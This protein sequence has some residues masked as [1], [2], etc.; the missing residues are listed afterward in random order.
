MEKV[1]VIYLG[2]GDQYQNYDISDLNLINKS[3]I[4][5]NFGQAG[6]YIEYFIYSLDG[7]LLDSNYLDNDYQIGNNVVDPVTGTTTK[8]YVDP[9]R[10]VRK[11]GYDRGQVNIVYNFLRPYLLS[12]PFQNQQFWI[13]EISTSRTEIK[14]ARQDLSNEQLLQ[15]FTTFNAVLAANPY[16][17]DFYLNFGDNQLIIGVNAVYV[18]E[19]ADSYVIFKLYEPLPQTFQTKS[20]FWVVTEIAEP[21]EY[22]VS[23]NVTP[24]PIVD[25]FQIKGPNYKVTTN[26]TVNQT[27]PFYN[28]TNLF[29]TSV[30]SSFQQ[31]KSLM[32]EKG[33]DI[34]VDYSNFSNFIH[35]SS[36]TERL[37]NFVYKLQL[38]E[39]AS[40]GLTQTNT[41]TAKV[42]L[43]AQID[44]TIKNFD[45]YEYFLYFESQSFA[46][47]KSTDVQPFQLYSVTSS[48]AQNWLGGIEVV[49]TATTASLYFSASLYD[50]TN[51]NLLE[52][53]TP[54][55]I[56]DD[57]NNEPY[58]V[59]LN[60]IGQHFDNIWIYLKDVSK[61]YSA[62]NNPFVG[63]SMDQVGNAL[64]SFGVRLYT[65]TSI[66]DNLYYSLLGINAD[67]SLLPPTGS[68][69]ITNYV[70]SS[71]A[72]LP[73]EQITGE[74]YKRLYHNLAYLFKTRGT[75]RGARAL[76]TTFGIP[77]SILTT[78]EYGGYNIYQYPGIQEINNTK[79]VTG[80][81]L[82]ISSSLLSP[83]ATLQ[84]YDNNLDKSSTTV[85][86]GFS[87]ADSINASIT[88]SGYVT[89]SN[90]P[91]Y[92]NIMQ[93]I[94][95][96]N[97]QYSSSYF[98][99]DQLSNTYF[100]AEYT[101]RYDVWDFIRII[102]YY[103]NSL[104]KMLRDW[105]PARVSGDTGIVIKSHMLERN[106][107]PRHE[108]TATTSS[109]DADYDLVRVTGSD[110]GAIQGNTN[111]V[112]LIPIQYGVSSSFL[113]ASFGGVYVSSSDDIQKYTGEFSGSTIFTDV[114][115]FSQTDYSS[116]TSDWTSSVAAPRVEMFLSY[117]LSPT[118]QNVTGS[119]ISQRF[120]DLD[121]NSSQL[122][123]V[124]YGL[125]TSSL[126][127]ALIIGFISQST[128]PYSQFAQFQDY[129]HVFRPSSIPRYSGSYLSG[130]YYNTH[131]F[132][133]VSY[134]NDPVINYY[135]DK[136]GF[137]NQ[138][139]TSSFLPGKVNVSLAYLSDVSGGLFELNQNNRNWEDVQRI[140][141]A[142]TVATVKQFDNKK[143]GN[144]VSTDGIKSLYNSGY[145]YTPQLYF[146]SG[147]D[148]RLYFQYAGVEPTQEVFQ[149]YN[150]GTPNAYIS[151]ATSPTYPVNVTDTVQ[152]SGDIFTIFDAE[153]PVSYGFF[154][155]GSAGIFPSFT[156]S[157][158]GQRTFTVNFG[159]NFE[160]QDP[161]LYSVASGSYSFGA[162]LNDSTLIGSLQTI[163]F[164]SSYTPG[165]FSTGSFTT[166]NPSP[167]VTGTP[168]YIT[169]IGRFNGPFNWTV[170]GGATTT[171]GSQT[172][173]LT[174]SLYTYIQ[175]G[176][177]KTG[178]MIQSQTSDL[179]PY[180][181]IFNGS[182]TPSLIIG[183]IVGGGSPTTGVKDY[184]AT[185]TFNY[186]TPAINLNTDDKVVFRFRQTGMSTAN[187]TSSVTFGT[188]N[189]SLTSTLVTI[190]QG[191]Y[192]Y[193]T[194]SLVEGNFIYDIVDVSELESNIILSEDL[195]NFVNYQFVPY[196]VSA[197]VA[198]S[199]SLY[200]GYGDINYSFDPQKGDKILLSDFSGLTQE[201]DVFSSSLDGNDR[202]NITVVPKVIDNW[203]VNSN[204]VLRC[205][206]LK[207]Y[208][209][210][211]NVILT[212]NKTPGLTSYGFLIPDTIS[213]QV[214]N[215]INTLQAAVQSQILTNQSVPPIDAISGGTFS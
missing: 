113:S 2:T 34:N 77:D 5:P 164:T 151:G 64:K 116:Y 163:N 148:N 112:E 117:S 31:I 125:I 108:P 56:R 72:T 21:A 145:N 13:K 38:I 208:N 115:Y 152:R 144:Q 181:T 52:Y 44:S 28:Y 97:L 98:P 172:S 53:T 24:R 154:G 199:S 78:H 14:V 210:E 122:A 60:M 65:N 19:G 153:T 133:D 147:T 168:S 211:Q 33:I 121:F 186:T 103:N 137:F 107:Y 36:A 156:A 200:F 105:Y 119:V 140:F 183:S 102:K 89:A 50:N 57:S 124:N 134:G 191:G 32:D 74:V 109:F 171:I 84:Y 90:Q 205:L 188:S 12:S 1:D 71:I 194:S 35:F 170:Q 83:Y 185:K 18:E 3:L 162:Y 141:K 30:S 136:L 67:G 58:L 80:S 46:W 189:S 87:P 173:Q 27:T 175:G 59:F 23:I 73:G 20:T 69:I 17:P 201:L 37:Y 96:P 146:I 177:S 25:R 120:L 66:S 106:K 126:N 179:N 41:S 203:I 206:I 190:G 135:S 159:V 45:G 128:Q 157:Y 166:A 111:Y 198:Y 88:S 195:S 213:P 149:G 138:I 139:E 54:Q 85:Q 132:G 9:E 62:E 40:A 8:I 91:G 16:Y 204:L 22:N 15:A 43:Q 104:F 81:V 180:L 207:R 47:P 123:P 49:P 70:T 76:I 118:F 174:A 127:Q 202:L 160:F 79:I 187:F 75:E 86:S 176:V 11:N 193:A 10:D 92:F 55:Y 94:G 99:L 51:S 182:S 26:S 169:Q 150:S 4:T 131:S 130:L 161:Q 214:T 167:T 101:A 215:N 192:P 68:E 212:F 197:S 48:Q 110:G 95:S 93:Y 129:L 7:Q 82:Q 39:T 29:A 178:V 143:F 196:F 6:D 142:G 165:G 42:L 100:N 61:R 209:D 155:V 63:I 114:N 184:I 158:T